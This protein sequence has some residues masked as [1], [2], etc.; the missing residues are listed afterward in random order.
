MSTNAPPPRDLTPLAT[1]DP[2]S[3][4]RTW[5]TSPHP[6]LPMVATACSDKTVRIYSLTSFTLLSVVSGGHKRS[7]R[8]VAWK[9]GTRGES[10]LATGSFDASAG[11]WRKYE[12]NAGA[13]G[14]VVL[15]EEDFTGGGGGG[16]D[17][18]DAESDDDYTFSVLLDG[19]E[20]E[21]KS[22]AFS[23]GGNLLATCS[24]DKSVWI[25]EELEDDNFETVAVLQEHEGDVKCVAW[26]PSE[27]LLASAS[28]DDTVRLWRE[29]LDDWG[30]C[31][32]LSGHRGT[33]WW[34]EFEGVEVSGMSGVLAGEGLREEQRALLEERERAGPR[35]VSCSDDL[36]I[37]IWRRIP[38]E[39][40][41]SSRGPNGVP[42]ILRTSSIEEDWVE[43]TRLPKAHGRAIYTATWSKKAG[44]IA[45]TGSDGKIVI[46]QE[47]WKSDASASAS[48]ASEVN[49]DAMDTSDGTLLAEGNQ[50]DS[51]LT[52]WVIIA[53]IEGAHGV[54]EV[55]HVC[56]TRRCDKGK[57]SSEEEV[58]VSTG[59]DGEVKV[60]TLDG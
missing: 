29:D 3:T 48:A 8:S 60:W 38:K 47:R 12:R 17:E 15:D 24:R 9:P 19:H 56:W 39:R 53:E 14:G 6:H 11:I 1:L 33:V 52:E 41:E 10:V 20:S 57:R 31:A 27:E 45:S 49:G 37:R 30:Q 59:D 44:L 36:T 54:F 50:K 18:G 40:G 51:S 35:L 16:G 2:P 46:Y 23:P 5:M 42:S 43:E 4:S 21:I 26:H 28:Y 7:I 34:V 22:L 55:N 25:W 58:I 32:L 13:E